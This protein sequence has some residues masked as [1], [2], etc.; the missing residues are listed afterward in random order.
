VKVLFLAM[1]SAGYGETLIGLSLARQLGD[2]GHQ[3]HFIVD[4]MSGPLL[5]GSGMSYVSLDAVMGP[6]ARLIVDAEI[7]AWHPD[8]IVLADYFTFCGVFA[9]RYEIDPWFVDDYGIPVVPIDIWELAGTSFEVD[10]FC[11]KRMAVDKHLL[12]YP[13]WLRPV[14]LCHV[15]AGDEP[16]AFPFQLGV[17]DERVSRRTRAHLREVFAIPPEGRLLLLALA[18]WQLPNYNDDN[19]NRVASVVPDLVMQCLADLPPDTHIVQVG[20]PLHGFDRLDPDRTHQ[21]PSCSPSR[22]NVLLGSVDAFVGLN[23]GATTLT[24]AVLAGVNGVVIQNSHE[25]DTAEAATSALEASGRQVDGNLRD[26]LNR[27]APLYPFRM[28]PLGFHSFLEPL[29]ENNPYNQAFR[30]VELLDRD[31]VTQ[32]IGASLFD[33]TTSAELAQGRQGYLDAVAQL[34]PTA[35]VFDAVTRSLGLG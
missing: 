19:G 23:V 30:T 10:V 9:K 4:T 3:C 25:A 29:L 24:R 32:T 26:W 8:V 27:A 22:F 7:S 13:A 21:M 11:G 12:D 18:S 31:L 16:R 28:W 6:L 1:S 5:D 15:S 14:P 33:S 2:A 20:Q 17:G 34:P 35:E